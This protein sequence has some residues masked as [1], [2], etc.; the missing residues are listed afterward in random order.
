[1]DKATKALL[2]A[3]SLRRELDMLD[4]ADRLKG[5]LNEQGLKPCPFCGNTKPRLMSEFYGKTYITCDSCGAF[6]RIVS[7]VFGKEEAEETV[8]KHWNAR[9]SS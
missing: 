5:Q 7:C 8:R 1:M 3:R 2:D 4:R 6:G 9:A